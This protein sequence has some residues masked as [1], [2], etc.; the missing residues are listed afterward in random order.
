MR[1]PKP[2]AA[3]QFVIV[4]SMVVWVAIVLP[5]QTTT[6]G[7]RTVAA[8]TSC[9]TLRLLALPNTTISSA[10]IVAHGAFA[11]TANELADH[12]PKT[13]VFSILPS[14]CR[15]SATVRPS[16][17]SEIKIEV[18]MP[19]SG[20]NG[21]FQGVGN[22]GWAGS[23]H[24][25]EMGDAVLAGYATAGTDTGHQLNSGSFGLGHPEKLTDFS[26]RAIHEMTV[27]AKVIVRTFY[28]TRPRLSF[29]NGCS[30]GG[31]QGLIEAD[32]YPTDFDGIVAGAPVLNWSRLNASRMAMSL[33]VHRSADS[34]IPPTKY[35]MIHHAVLEACDALDGVKD[36][37]LEDP[38]RCRF[39]PKVLECK[40]SDG[41][42]CLAAAQVRTAEDL[43]EPIRSPKTGAQ[44]AP[45]LMQ[46]G[47]ELGWAWVAGPEPMSITKEFFEYLVYKDP[48]W[49]WHRFNPAT[50]IDATLAADTGLTDF[51]YPTLK[52]FFDRGG[53][54]LIYHGWSDPVITPMGTVEYFNNEVKT[55]GRNVVGKSIELYMVPGMEHCRD[56]A[57][58][59]VFDKMAAIERWVA[60]GTAPDQILASHRTGMTVD[61]TRWLCTFGKVDM[62]KGSGS[63]EDA[64]NFS[65][66][67]LR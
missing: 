23:I 35:P 3:Y 43:Y 59:D 15:V 24:Y 14:F 57:G 54:L 62:Y 46:P 6:R 66:N 37:V 47:S 26:Y 39:N 33:V 8:E 58:T 25:V 61:R 41:P 20:W 38:R 64:K 28:G 12:E 55:L 7:A 53:K 1:R 18:W 11:P 48:R 50:D 52:P 49:D 5:A 40:E 27:L 10:I 34:Y 51:D 42:D 31:H 21:K 63:T 67:A 44:V 17:D 29:F 56:G 65:C 22:G 19:A 45:G 2:I 32:R 36:G 30:L 9:Q 16:R 4:L 60:E 13:N